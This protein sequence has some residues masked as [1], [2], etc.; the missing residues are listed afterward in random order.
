MPIEFDIT[1][2]AK[3]MYRFNMYQTYSGFH[4]WFSV[5]VS[6]L[7]FV[8]AGMTYG[9]IEATYTILYVVFGIIFLVY[10]PLS[11]SIRSKHALA[12]SEVLRNA[13]HYVV[14]EN[15]FTVSQGDANAELPWTQIYKMVTTKHNVLVYS[16]RT[17]AYVIPREQLGETTYRALAEIA[18]SKLEKFRVKMK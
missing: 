15:G 10:P 7:I 14:G 12:S 5:I 9:D 11:L 17:N 1:L 2:T 16:N 4:G 6:V 18:N 8:V 13:L 3:D